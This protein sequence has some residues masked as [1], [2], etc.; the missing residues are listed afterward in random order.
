MKFRMK[1]FPTH[2]YKLTYHYE[3]FEVHFRSLSKFQQV[4]KASLSV[5]PRKRTQTP[6][7]S[8]DPS[9]QYPMVHLIVHL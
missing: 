3:K 6:L 1:E 9:P 8:P 2:Y 4:S 5:L 7:A